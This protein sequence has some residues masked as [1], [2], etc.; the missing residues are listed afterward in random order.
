MIYRPIGNTGMAASVVGLGCEHLD[1]RPYEKVAE[2]VAGALNCGMNIMDVFM[3]GAPVRENIAKALGK[4]RKDV[5]LQGHIGSVDL[6]EQYD[7]TRDVGVCRK[8]FEDLLRLFGGY[9]DLGMMFFVDSE[10]DF[11][12]VFETKYIDYVLG[13]KR[14]GHIRAIGASSHNPGTAA[15]IVESGVVEL[16]MFSVNPAFDM[17]PVDMTI[18]DMLEKKDYGEELNMET[19][20]ARLY[21]LCESRGVAVTT[22]KTL[23]AGKLLAREFTPFAQPLT[24]PQCIHYALTR[25]AVVSALIGCSSGR[26]VREAARYLDAGDEQ[27]DFSRVIA[28][29]KSAAHAQCLYCNHCLPCPVG[30][31]IAAL[32]RLMDAASLDGQPSERMRAQYGALAHAAS[33]CIFC[34]HCEKRCPFGVAV[35]ENMSRAMRLFEDRTG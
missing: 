25:P 11:K 14:E 13:L 26:E 33:A 16:L 4:R 15:K 19:A 21:R 22:M 28:S 32:T 7:I 12:K 29:R 23:G 35:M 24:V 9:I 27:K 2:T 18:E 20:R 5:L 34:G 8:Y 3:P 17:L 30:I 6:R 31:D 1:N 10:D